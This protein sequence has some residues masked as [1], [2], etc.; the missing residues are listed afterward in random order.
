[1][2]RFFGLTTL[3]Y[4]GMVDRARGFRYH[5]FIIHLPIVENTHHIEFVA[6]LVDAD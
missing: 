1:M 3:G 5:V 6:R 4:F 2:F